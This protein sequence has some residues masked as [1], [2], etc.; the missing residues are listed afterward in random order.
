MSTR[1]QLK[2]HVSLCSSPRPS[3]APTPTDPS[4]VLSQQS[5]AGLLRPAYV[6]I[7]DEQMRCILLCIRGT[8]S[9]KDLFTSLAGESSLPDLYIH[10]FSTLFTMPGTPVSTF[11]VVLTHLAMTH[12][13][14]ELPS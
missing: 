1:S 5:N 9:T 12:T 13:N 7:A 14:P 10:L 4:W 3:P 6:L 8:Q 11:L 2:G